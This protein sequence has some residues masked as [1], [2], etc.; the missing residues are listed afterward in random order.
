MCLKIT[1]SINEEILPTKI[2]KCNIILVLR[3]IQSH[4]LVMSFLI[5]SRPSKLCV[6]LVV[7]FGQS[8]KF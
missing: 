7:P 8:F 3:R 2:L 5:M 4:P 1:N 6:L